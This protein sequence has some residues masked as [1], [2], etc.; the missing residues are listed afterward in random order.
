MGKKLAIRGHLTRG[1]E[2]IELLEMMGGINSDNFR[3]TDIDDVYFVCEYK[4]ICFIDV[5]RALTEDD[6]YVVFSLYEFYKKYP[7]KVGDVVKTGTDEESI[8]K[9]IKWVDNDIVYWVESNKTCKWAQTLSV[10]VLN[11]YNRLNSNDVDVKV[12]STGFM[13]VG[14]TVGI[15][16]NE[17]NYE[18]EVELQLGDYEIEVR[19]GKTYAVLKKSKYPKTIEECVKL[20][21]V[22]FKLDMNSYKRKLMANFHR[23]II[24]RDAYWKIAGKE[25]RLGKHWKPDWTSGKPFYCISVSGNTIGK[26]KWYTDNKILAFPTEEMRDAFYENFKDL[27]ESCKELL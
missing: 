16:F 23:L 9:Q 14:K 4:D 1:K 24:C 6:N 11:K 5:D 7:Y 2:V 12:E 13:Q 25:I 27:I 3:G 20:L 10:D 18:D 22:D 8:I 15:I 19:N 21:R 17:A 26:G